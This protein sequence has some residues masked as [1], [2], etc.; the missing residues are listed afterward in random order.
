MLATT[1]EFTGDARLTPPAIPT[2]EVVVAAPPVP[3]HVAGSARTTALI[4]VGVLAAV[5][6]VVWSVR[7]GATVSPVTLL[8]PVLALISTLTMALRGGRDRD[9]AR[10]DDQRR[11]YL[12]HLDDLGAQLDA[13]AQRQRD[14]LTWMHPAP[15]A[16]WSLVGGPR[17]WERRAADRD[18]GHVRIGVGAQRQCRPIVLPPTAPAADLDPVTAEAFRR[19]VHHH[20]IVGEVPIALAITGVPVIAVAGPPQDSRALMRAM[21]CQLAVLHAPNVILIAALVDPARRAEW[22][23]LKWLPHTRHPRSG[24]PMVY[25]RAEDLEAVAADTHR[26]HLFVV[27]DRS[28]GRAPRHRAAMTTVSMGSTA[29]VEALSILIETGRLIVAGE[30]CAR[31]D[32]LTVEQARDC[33]RWLARYRATRPDA[34][35]AHRWGARFG[36]GSA[37]PWPAHENHTALRIPLGRTPDGEIVELDIKE[38][39]AGGHGPHGLCVGA[40]GSGKSE[41][42]RT[43][44]TGM[45]CLHPPDELNLVLIDFKGGA[46]FR[47]LSGLSH[48]AAIITNLSEDDHLVGSAQDALAGEIHRRQ[49]LF[50]RAGDAVNLDAYRQARQDDPRLPVLPALFVVV[51][52]FTELLARQPDFADLFAT[53]GRVGRSL[54]VH[55]LL[56]SQRLDEGRLRGLESHLSYRICLKTSSAAESRA[57]LGVP[58]AVDLPAA[59]G[60]AFLRD[61]DGR[62]S[63]FQTT[64][65]GVPVVDTLPVTSEAVVRQFTSVPAADP[66]PSLGGTRTVLD[67]I[68]DQLSGQGTPARQIWLAPLSSSPRLSDLTQAGHPEL[69]ATIGLI[70][71]PFDQCRVPLT[72]HT[73]GAGGHVAIVGTPQSG[74][75]QAVCTVIRALAARHNPQ[76]IQFYCL[77]FGGGGLEALRVLPHVGTVAPRHHPELVHATLR[78]VE[79]IVRSREAGGVDEFGDVYLVID[80]WQSLREEFGELEPRVTALAAHSLSFGVHLILTAGRWADIR[81]GLKDQI[82]TRLE[83][84]LGDPL[85]S[86]MNRKQAALV[87]LGMPGRGLT[88]DG[89]HFAIATSADCD[90]T[91]PASW[92][93]PP[94]RLLPARV[95]YAEVVD[96]GAAGSGV[97]IGIG[98]PEL[99]PTVLEFSHDGHL[100][101]VGDRD[102]GKSATLRTLCLDIVRGA[103]PRQAQLYLVDFRRGLLGLVDPAYLHGYAFSPAALADS[104]PA[105]LTMLRNR[106]PAADLTVDQLR[107]RSWWDGPDVFIVVDDHDLVA[108]PGAD[109]LAAVSDLLPHA[110]DIGLHLIIARPWAGLARALY[111]PLLTHLRD[112]RCPTLLMSGSPDEGLVIGGHRPTPQPPGRG[113]L[114]RA[115]AAQ[116]I[117]VYW[118]PP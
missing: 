96:H 73:R 28:D 41:L 43:V 16:L 107:T 102:C 26:P 58:D 98:E 47:G 70:D 22:D 49:Q 59:P 40:T 8:L 32:A 56:A 74:K 95:D 86:E 42:L 60:A 53:I 11:R 85:D 20:C 15:T 109:G 91:A 6:V 3:E 33:A 103:T 64:Y 72:V 12:E 93:S 67:T 2:G 65:L 111:D 75:S 46:T 38:P 105:L 39:A 104:L 14:V 5:G 80:G 27:T 79:T 84:R 62:V 108:G 30:E 115:D 71:R 94:V 106:L 45:A 97:L 63:R 99:T 17:M 36:S 18:V 87:P 117:Q 31:P 110:S 10:L 54:G 29:D 52:E 66:A 90:V 9:S 100:V 1:I 19:W 112:N 92:Q 23:W 78:H 69:S 7:S 81:P 13:A 51:D 35:D 37:P 77:D 44:V 116:R 114:I 21:V 101:I 4:A 57:V 82:G 34:D 48:V 89:H 55:L 50:A 83:L 61:G 68:L 24:T 88:R 25:E 118:S 76:R 113:L